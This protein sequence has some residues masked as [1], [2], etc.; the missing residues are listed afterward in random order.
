MNEQR[1]TKLKEYAQQARL[2]TARLIH[3]AG[4]GHIGGDFS[5]AELITALYHEILNVS[6]ADFARPPAGE[7]PFGF[8]YT[9]KKANPDRDRFLLSKGHS[10]EMLLVTLAERGFFPVASLSDYLTKGSL[11]IGHPSR[12]IPGI[13]FNTGALGHGLGVA[14][15][16]A[17]AAKMDERNYLTWVLMGDGEL[18]EGSIWEAAQA[19]AHY[20]LGKLVAILDRN[21]LQNN[22]STESLMS[23]GDIAAKWAAFGWNVTEIPDGNDMEQVVTTLTRVKEA[24]M[25]SDDQGRPQ[26]IIAHTEKGH[27]ISLAAGKWQWHHHVPTAEEMTLIEAELGS[28]ATQRGDF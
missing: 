2:A 1:I 4:S 3:R 26:M 18:D 21:G 14:V 20:R 22:G 11:L 27:G 13:E 23:H 6:P 5:E 19:A 7:P 10:V 16:M 17:L 15:G 8:D 24:A 12:N 9:R 25:R 28:L